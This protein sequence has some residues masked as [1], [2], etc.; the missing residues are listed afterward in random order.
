MKG[1]LREATGEGDVLEI[2]MNFGPYEIV[3]TIGSGSSAVVICVM[4]VRSERKFAAKVMR[5]PTSS[6]HSLRFIER[7]LRLCVTM[8]CPYL[9][10]CTDVI[11]LPDLICVIMEYFEGMDMFTMMIEE[12]A[13][14]RGNWRSIFTQVCLGVQYLHKRGLAHRDLKMEN[15][16]IDKFMNVKLCDYGFMCETSSTTVSTSLCGT[17]QYIAPEVVKG[18]GY[19]AMQSDIWALGMTLFAGT[20]GFFPWRSADAVG[21][22]REILEANV[23]V[24]MLPKGARE[25]VERCFEK[26]PDKRATIDEIMEMGFVEMPAVKESKTMPS[27]FRKKIEKSNLHQI[28]PLLR[29][30]ETVHGRKMVHSKSPVRSM[31][32]RFTM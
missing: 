22:C 5:R 24:R 7:E 17:T 2:P 10:R 21:M 23:D 9:V 14:L 12:I 11:Y 30:R 28:R 13:V 4:D 3:R 32:A 25:I 19:Q 20:T 27:L 29:R 1:V 15:I 31:M 16:L 8:S 6:D 26:N 18:E